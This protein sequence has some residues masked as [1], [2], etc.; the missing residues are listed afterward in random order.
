MDQFKKVAISLEEAQIEKLN[1]I[2]SQSQGYSRS[3]LVREAVDYYLGYLAQAEN[4][5][6]LSPLIT[7]SIKLTLAR[8][9]ENLSEMLFKLAVEI[10]KSNIL[11]A[12][13]R[14]LSDEALDYLNRVSKRI[15]AEN[16]GA[17]DLEKS[18]DYLY[19]NDFFGEE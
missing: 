16:N 9:E 7:Q 12:Y 13:N 8:F 10:C 1:E 4:V 14:D 18:Q 19:E 15:V 6:Y 17:I 2:A 11:T 3:A 5:N